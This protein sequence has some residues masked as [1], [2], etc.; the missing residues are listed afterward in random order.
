MHVFIG[1]TCSY[2]DLTS[3]M[4]LIT[5]VNTITA[6]CMCSGEVYYVT[7]GYRGT[8]GKKGQQWHIYN[9]Q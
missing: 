4:V 1:C 5:G 2:C 9:N 3:T 7:L 6:C 8:V